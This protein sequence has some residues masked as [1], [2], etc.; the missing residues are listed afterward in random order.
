MRQYG[1]LLLAAL[2][3]AGCSKPSLT[4]DA[5]GKAI[6][7]SASFREPGFVGVERLEVPSPCKAKL[8]EDANWRALAAINW[9]EV[10]DD[11]DF[12]RGT[13]GQPAIKCVG[14]L[15]G[16]GLRAGASVNT[17]TYNEWRV[18]AASRELVS[19]KSVTSPDHGIST[20]GFTYRWN[21]N[22]FGSQVLDPGTEVSGVAVLRLL[23]TGWQVAEF[24]V[25]PE[26]APGRKASAGTAPAEKTQP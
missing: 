8:Q 6:R 14:R 16:D 26:F 12:E 15:S 3:L 2:A 9:L 10:R 7:E 23:D 11:E 21:L 19:V 24:T 13:E 18:P 25:M 4:A 1:I 17:T 5:A 20:V 22:L